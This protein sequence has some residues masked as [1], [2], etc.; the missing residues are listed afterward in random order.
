MQIILQK[1]SQRK[2]ERVSSH[3]SG[4]Y[5]TH[6]FHF[7]NP[8]PRKAQNG[9]LKIRGGDGRSG[10]HRLMQIALML[11]HTM[12]P[13]AIPEVERYIYKS[14][15]MQIYHLKIRLDIS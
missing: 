12:L 15:Y 2:K 14:A 13:S 1:I 11:F 10:G 4:G 5:L 6:F 8:L 7:K 9:D 3:R